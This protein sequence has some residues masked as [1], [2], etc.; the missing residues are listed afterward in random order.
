MRAD[1]VERESA[2]KED[3]HRLATLPKAGE[4][5]GAE[6]KKEREN[7][8]AATRAKYRLVKLLELYEIGGIDKQ[9]LRT[10]LA[11]IASAAENPPS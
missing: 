1:M 3:S 2:A 8:S 9:T 10:R 5:S 6:A 11:R 7:N 4:P